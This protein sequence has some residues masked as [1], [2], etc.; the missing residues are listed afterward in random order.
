M[1]SCSVAIDRKDENGD[2]VFAIPAARGDVPQPWVN[3]F[4]ALGPVGAWS[5]GVPELSEV[6]REQRGP[7]GVA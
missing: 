6:Q 3:P 4:T 1:R 7:S 5:D 2:L